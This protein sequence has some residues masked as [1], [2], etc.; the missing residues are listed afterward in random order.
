MYEACVQQMPW[1]QAM[2]RNRNQQTGKLT[3][4][5]LISNR[6]DC[7]YRG[8]HTGIAKL[9]ETIMRVCRDFRIADPHAFLVNNWYPDGKCSIGAHSHDHWSAILSFGSPR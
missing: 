2:I 3:V 9:D 7:I 4:T 6:L 8:L 1:Q 5:G